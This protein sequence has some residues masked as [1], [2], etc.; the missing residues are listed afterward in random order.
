MNTR[1]LL[2]GLFVAAALA[3]IT[4]ATAQ[5]LETCTAPCTLDKV[6]QAVNCDIPCPRAEVSVCVPVCPIT[7]TQWMCPQPPD[8]C[9]ILQRSVDPCAVCPWPP[10]L[11][12][13]CG[14]VCEDARSLCGVCYAF[15]MT[16]NPCYPTV[17]DLRDRAC[18][19]VPIGWECYANGNDP[20]GLIPATLDYV[21]DMGTVVCGLAG[22]L[23]MTALEQASDTAYFGVKQGLDTVDHVRNLQIYIGGQ[24]DDHGLVQDVLGTVADQ[25]NLACDYLLGGPYCFAGSGPAP[26]QCAVDLPDSGG[27]VGATLAYAE[28]ACAYADGE[29][30]AIADDAQA[31]AGDAVATAGSIAAQVEAWAQAYVDARADDADAFKDETEANANTAVTVVTSSAQ[32]AKYETCTYLFGQNC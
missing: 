13:S 25:G 28:T 32:A 22:G 12:V 20:P 2:A 5:S 16:P 31:I 8:P 14:P 17:C 3:N 30:A 26:G 9:Q 1:I 6:C 21:Q 10:A 24:W 19:D 27:V 15:A 29:A 4:P 7:H 11:D 23:T 18:Y